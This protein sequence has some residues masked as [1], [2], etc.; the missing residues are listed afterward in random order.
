MTSQARRA[1]CAFASSYRERA[2]SGSGIVAAAGWCARRGGLAHGHGLRGG[3]AGQ[4]LAVHAL[5]GVELA[6]EAQHAGLRE[7]DVDLRLPLGRD[8]LVHRLAG[9]REVVLRAR[10]VLDLE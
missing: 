2:A 4:Q 8:I 1:S 3:V 7:G 9:E 10:F 5:V 6:E